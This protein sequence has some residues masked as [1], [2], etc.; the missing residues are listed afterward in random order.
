[1]YLLVKFCRIVGGLALEIRGGINYLLH[2][3]N[4]GFGTSTYYTLEKSEMALDLLSTASWPCVL[5]NYIGY[6]LVHIWLMAKECVLP[7]DSISVFRY[8]WQ[9]Y[10]VSY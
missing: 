1:M 5:K 2:Q 6:H 3:T 4:K 8:P 7:L 10:V 9:S